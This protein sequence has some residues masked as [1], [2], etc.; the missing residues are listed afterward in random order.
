MNA[1]SS[2]GSSI[3]GRPVIVFIPGTNMTDVCTRIYLGTA[4]V[5]AG[6]V[7]G[8]LVSGKGVKN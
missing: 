7:H 8:E 1:V 2:A 4:N 6:F 5:D 3:R